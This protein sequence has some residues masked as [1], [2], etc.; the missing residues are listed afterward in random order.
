MWLC[1]GPVTLVERQEA[2]RWGSLMI[3]GLPQQV[4]F[5]PRR[6]LLRGLVSTI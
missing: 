2:Q 6:A 4:V 5:H 3:K 1:T